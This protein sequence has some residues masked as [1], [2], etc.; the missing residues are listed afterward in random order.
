MNLR[1]DILRNSI[2]RGLDP[3]TVPF[4]PSDLGLIANNYGSFSD[5]CADTKSSKYS[6][7][8]TLK[9][10]EWSKTGKPLKYLLLE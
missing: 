4:K 9:V 7:D 2:L 6:R 10:V 3:F 5:H 1:D 8:I